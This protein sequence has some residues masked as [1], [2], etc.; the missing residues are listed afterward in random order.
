MLD[1][2]GEFLLNYERRLTRSGS[3]RFVAWYLLSQK[4]EERDAPIFRAEE[5]AYS[6]QTSVNI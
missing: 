5:A 1:I 4:G 3:W 2:C 6:S